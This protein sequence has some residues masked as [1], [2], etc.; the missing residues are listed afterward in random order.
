MK[1][2][3]FAAFLLIVSCLTVKAQEALFSGNDITS[4]E[5]HPDGS[6]TFRLYAPKA[7][8]VKLTGDFLPKTIVNSPFGKMETDTQAE[9]KEVDGIWTYTTPSLDPELYTYKFIVDG[10]ERTDPSNVYMCRD[11]ASYFNIFI[12]EKNP[13]DK[14][15][16]YSVN[17]VPHGNVSKVW[18]DSP[19]LQTQRRMTVYT[20]A[21]YDNGSKRY[22]V[23]YLLHGAGGD[24][25]AWTTLGRAQHILDNLIASGKVKPMIVVMTNGNA[26]CQAAPGE[27]S[28]GFYK[29]SFYG[30]ADGQPV[31]STQDS[32]KDVV[33]YIDSHYRTLANKKN[34][35]IAG[36]S[37][38]GGHS[39]MISRNNPDMFNYV[40][41]FSA[42]IALD[43]TKAELTMEN[44][45]IDPKT[46]QQLQTLFAK[47]PALYWIAIGNTD[48]LYKN[49]ADYV[50]Y[51]NDK[52]Y[53]HE[54]VETDGGHIWRNWRIYLTIFSQRL[55]K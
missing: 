3:L 29:P 11:I 49:N 33:K 16:L 2:T 45:T 34:R 1:K 48:F 14:G 20:P 19:T 52:G 40:G 28:K 22:P 13:G 47:K 46:E 25:D 43:Q 21:G 8:S 44:P 9:M 53:E 32:Y 18:Y 6:V 41:L 50:K 23:L 4:P 37:M 30:H 27:W 10:L 7:V 42:A 31:A 17:E 5:V 38:G 36:L 24:E 12:V 54:Y 35:A 39:F 26:N 15:D 51:L 55:F